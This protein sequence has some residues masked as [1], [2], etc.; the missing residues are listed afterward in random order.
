MIDLPC[1]KSIYLG[2]YALYGDYDKYNS[3]IM[4]GIIK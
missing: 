3:L 1:L 2:Y 4:E